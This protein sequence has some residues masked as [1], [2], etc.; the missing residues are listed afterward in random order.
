MVEMHW[1][2]HVRIQV[3]CR[4]HGLI[5]TTRGSTGKACAA[6]LD[7]L[8]THFPD[9][10]F[11]LA[12]AKARDMLQDVSWL[13]HEAAILALGAVGEGQSCGREA[14][15]GEQD[16]TMF[17]VTAAPAFL[18]IGINSSSSPLRVSLPPPFMMY[19]SA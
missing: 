3:L 8:T 11:P 18:Q 7:V 14:R 16:S 6:T 2:T 12:L 4:M 9:A 17:H 19:R 13:V 5:V 1:H 10:V 15:V